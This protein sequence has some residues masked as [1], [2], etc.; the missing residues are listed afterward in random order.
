MVA[1]KED[2]KT[3][4]EPP[5]KNTATMAERKIEYEKHKKKRIKNFE[6]RR[7]II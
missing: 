6:M 2:E 4:T 5:N 3:A 7:K 1:L